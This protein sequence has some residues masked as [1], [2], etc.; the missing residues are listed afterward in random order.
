M[1]LGSLEYQ[2]S[3]EE[4]VVKLDWSKMPEGVVLL[5]VLQDWIGYLNDIYQ[6]K[7]KEVFTQGAKQ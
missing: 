6:A 1:K 2:L 5:D 4:G 7:H 3:G